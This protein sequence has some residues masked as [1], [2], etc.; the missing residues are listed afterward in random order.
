MCEG[1]INNVTIWEKKS[2]FVDFDHVYLFKG[3][4]N[5][6]KAICNGVGRGSY[7]FFSKKGKSAEQYVCKL[8][9]WKLHQDP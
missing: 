2:R 3:P 9:V 5:N 1:Q 8:I 6:P 7:M 4:S